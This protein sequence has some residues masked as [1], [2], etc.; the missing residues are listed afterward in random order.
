MASAFVVLTSV[1]VTSIAHSGTLT[2]GPNLGVGV[3]DEPGTGGDAVT[4][5]G[6]PNGGGMV[7]GSL[8]PG[9][10][11]GYVPESGQFDVYLDTGLNY[12]RTR[13]SSFK[14]ILGSLNLQYNLAPDATTTTYAVLGA[15][16]SHIGDR[17]ASMTDLIVGAGV[18][19][20]RMVSEEHGAV[21][22]ELR[23]DRLI[24]DPSSIDLNSFALKL[25]VDL[26][27]P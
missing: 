16:L 12:S 21:R 17:Y 1:H 20:R 10:R 6:V 23:Y 18:G 22:A 19:L 15:G 4:S 8:Q 2:I 24:G 3:V 9:L 11:F 27:I 5:V 7:F 26:W 14:T 13:E 25:G